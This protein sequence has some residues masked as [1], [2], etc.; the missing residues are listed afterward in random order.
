MTIQTPVEEI[1]DIDASD[2]I[3]KFYWVVTQETLELMLKK[4]Q[5]DSYFDSK[6]E[7]GIACFGRKRLDQKGLKAISSCFVQRPTTVFNT[8]VQ[9]LNGYRFSK[10]SLNMIKPTSKLASDPLNRFPDE[11]SLIPRIL[12]IEGNRRRATMLFS[13]LPINFSKHSIKRFIKRQELYR[14]PLACDGIYDE[15]SVGAMNGLAMLMAYSRQAKRIENYEV[16]IPGKIGVF[17]GHITSMAVFPHNSEHYIKIGDHFDNRVTYVTP[18]YS[19]Y[20]DPSTGEMQQ[21]IINIRTWVAYEDMQKKE[22]KMVAEKIL[23]RMV[24]YGLAK[25]HDCVHQYLAVHLDPN[26]KEPEKLANLLDD[27]AIIG[28][29]TQGLRQKEPV[30]EEITLPPI[31]N[32]GSSPIYNMNDSPPVMFGAEW[33]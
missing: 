24:A 3:N 25:N 13:Y 33:Y 2:E 29:R 5:E 32:I 17:F 4:E 7:A 14:A 9:E 11:I 8:K 23:D 28:K 10:V 21:Y 6:I 1:R 18:K 31:H 19:Y 15:F 26:T 27:L 20:M 30:I 16:I 22:Q 12:H